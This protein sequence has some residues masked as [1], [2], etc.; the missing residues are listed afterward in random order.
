[1]LGSADS[2]LQGFSGTSRNATGCVHVDSAGHF[3]STTY[4]GLLRTRWL[5]TS[6]LLGYHVRDFLNLRLRCTV[7]D[8]YALRPLRCLYC[9]SRHPL[10]SFNGELHATLC[11]LR[12][13]VTLLQR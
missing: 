7:V 5:T 12:S 6:V 8:G 10:L 3:A 11:L 2:S 13:P 9:D 1:L 4:H